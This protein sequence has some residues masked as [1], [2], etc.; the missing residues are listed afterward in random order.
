M[1]F[2][3]MHTVRLQ[4]ED[5]VETDVIMVISFVFPLVMPGHESN[6]LPSV[7]AF[8]RTHVPGWDQTAIVRTERKKEKLIESNN[9][10][11][12]HYS[13]TPLKDH[14]SIKANCDITA[15]HLGP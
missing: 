14:P 1:A 3:A 13:E 10:D 5:F 6:R 12:L 4:W 2:V 8:Q 7:H 15:T 11:V 9:L